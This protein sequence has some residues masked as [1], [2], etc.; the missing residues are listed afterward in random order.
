MRSGNR[1]LEAIGCGGESQLHLPSA[2]SPIRYLS[3]S[4]TLIA[5]SK[6]SNGISNRNK[7]TRPNTDARLNS[8]EFYEPGLNRQISIRE[9]GRVDAFNDFAEHLSNVWG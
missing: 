1:L 4:Q 5:L 2:T 9:M 3:D 6:M 7:T 8:D